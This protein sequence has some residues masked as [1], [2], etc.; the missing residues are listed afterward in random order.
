MRRPSVTLKCSADV[1]ADKTRERIV[2]FSDPVLGVGGLISFRRC[3]DGTL[4]VQAYRCDE[5]V[6]VNPAPKA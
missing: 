6:Q 4:L 5:K 1:Y 2:E 3:D